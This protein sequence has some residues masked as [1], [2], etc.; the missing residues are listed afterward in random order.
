M[1]DEKIVDLFFERNE[2]AIVNCEIK[3]GSSLRVLG[4][5]I[6]H[7]SHTT[8]ECVD[9]TYM[10]TWESVPPNNPRNHLFAY[11]A[12][13]LRNVC[14][15]RIK[16]IA[17]SKRGAS[18]TVLSNELTEAVPDKSGADA[19]AL[20]NELSELITRFV[21]NLPEE[22]KQIFVLRYFYMEDLKSISKRLFITEGK[23]KT[24]LH[25]SRLK[26]KLFLENYGYSI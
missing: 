2:S 22:Q 26:L 8:D 18:V 6:V 15:D 5:R 19:D 16:L 7:D 12:K 23:V 13:I 25:R 20:R 11:L 9:D 10:K 1:T 21:K 4:K 24:V 14:F 17:R 3:Y